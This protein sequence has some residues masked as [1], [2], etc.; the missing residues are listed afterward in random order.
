[1]AQNT[2]A[3]LTKAKKRGIKLIKK[4]IVIGIGSVLIAIAFNALIIPYGLLS[5]GVSGIALIINYLTGFP[6]YIG[7]FLL[8]IPIFIWGAKELDRKLMILSL[9]GTVV[10]IIAIPLTKP[11]IPVPQVDLFLASIFSGIVSGIGGGIIF[12]NGASGGGTDIISM[13]IKKK[14][15]ISI[16]AFSFYLNIFVLAASLFFFDLKIALYTLVSMW[17]SGKVTDFVVEGLDHKKSIMIISEKN[18][19]IAELIMKELK[20]GVTYFQ[21]EG[22]FTGSNKMIINTVVN[23]I[24]NAKIREIICEVDPKAFMYI[25]EAIEVSGKGFT[26]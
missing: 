18:A 20:R 10:M 15:N 3:A 6:L 2:K 21:G 19:E 5:G 12:R 8:N 1:M 26:R 9:V 7:I 11:Y 17:V 22:A 25:T 4:L 13:I 24:E 16:G 23:D 14:A